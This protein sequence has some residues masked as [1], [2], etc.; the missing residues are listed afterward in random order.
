MGNVEAIYEDLEAR[1]HKIEDEKMSKDDVK[2]VVKEDLLEQKEVEKRK[3]NVMC[4]NVLKVFSI[5]TMKIK[6]S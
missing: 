6:T 4:Y 5:D 3:L 1:V 2:T